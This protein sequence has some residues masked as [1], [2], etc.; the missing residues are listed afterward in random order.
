MLGGE[1]KIKEEEINGK[2][3]FLFIR[4]IMWIYNNKVL[5]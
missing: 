4:N 5:W 2:I 1:N 3:I